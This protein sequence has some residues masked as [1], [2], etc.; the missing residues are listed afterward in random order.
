MVKSYKEKLTTEDLKR[1]K[2][3]LKIFKPKVAEVIVAKMLENHID[4]LSR[5]WKNTPRKN[6]TLELEHLISTSYIS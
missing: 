2:E 1:G 6:P 4:T 3:R 5:Q